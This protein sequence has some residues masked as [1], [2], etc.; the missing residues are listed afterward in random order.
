MS[1]R[2]HSVQ[3]FSMSIG[4]RIPACK[5]VFSR[6]DC[7]DAEDVDVSIVAVAESEC[8]MP[9]DTVVSMGFDMHWHEDTGDGPR[10]FRKK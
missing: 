9:F 4:G 6:G 3:P 5:L 2:R 10:V 7:V 1:Q 8:T